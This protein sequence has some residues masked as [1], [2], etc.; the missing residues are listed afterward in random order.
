MFEKK[1]QPPLAR[2]RFRI[3]LMRS[4][5]LAFTIISLSLAGGMWGYHS[6][7]GMPWIDSYLEASMILSGMGPTGELHTWWGKFFAGSYALYSGLALIITVGVVLAPILHRFFHQF[8]FDV[9]DNKKS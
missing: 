5:A 6:I 2:N 3:R 1:T 4:L 8:H 9:D 7:E